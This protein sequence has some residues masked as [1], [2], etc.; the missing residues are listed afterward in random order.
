MQ[1]ERQ[2]CLGVRHQATE[3]LEWVE[4][5]VSPRE[6]VHVVVGAGE[7]GRV[8]A[9]SGT[10]LQHAGLVAALVLQHYRD[11]G[12][13]HRHDSTVKQRSKWRR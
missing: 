5:A 4:E 9:T 11:A 12:Q 13:G 2:G 10:G 8:E 7:R 1:V 6:E 3:G